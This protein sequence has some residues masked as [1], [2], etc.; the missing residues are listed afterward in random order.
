MK[1][2]RFRDLQKAGIVMS[3]PMLRCRVDN[4]GFPPGRKLGGNTRAWTE[5]EVQAWLDSRPTARKAAP[6]RGQPRKDAT[7]VA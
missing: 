3:W 1:F 6:P 4:D 5:E 7:S 2:L